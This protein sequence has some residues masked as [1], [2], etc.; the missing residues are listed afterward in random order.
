MAGSGMGY[1]A[2]PGGGYGMSQ[3]MGGGYGMSQGMGGSPGMGGMGMGMGGM[4]MGMGGQSMGMGGQPGM[5][6]QLPPGQE[7]P[8]PAP[9]PDVQDQPNQGLILAAILGGSAI[10][11]I[12]LGCAMFRKKGGADGDSDEDMDS[13]DDDESD[14]S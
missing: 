12:A 10:L 11:G 8:T 9:L 7:M 14:E 4:G 2:P 6:G 3:G 1:G 13:D 5:P